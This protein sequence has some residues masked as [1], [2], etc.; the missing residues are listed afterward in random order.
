VKKIIFISMVAL[1]II[2]CAT[3]SNLQPKENELTLMQRK[4]PGITLEEVQQGFRLY[5]TNCSG[6]HSL[7]TPNAYNITGWEKVLPEM[8]NRAKMNSEKDILLL[9]NY[10]FAKSK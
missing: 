3:V 2:G 5:K 7:Y 4:V 8:T 9:K 1:F 6:C 10:L